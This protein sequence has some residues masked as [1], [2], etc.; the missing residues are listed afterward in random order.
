MIPVACF[1]C[2]KRFRNIEESYKKLLRDLKSSGIE[3]FEAVALD[4]LGLTRW[5]CRRMI[6]THIPIHQIK[7]DYIEFTKNMPSDDSSHRV[8]KFYGKEDSSYPQKFGTSLSEVFNPKCKNNID[9]AGAEKNEV[10]DTNKRKRVADC[11]SHKSK[12][13]KL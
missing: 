6:I 4:K 2:R 13:Q 9:V 11:S 10:Y 3:N 5:C 1:T 8:L 7:M 12:K